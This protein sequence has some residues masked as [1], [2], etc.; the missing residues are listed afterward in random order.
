MAVKGEDLA[1]RVSAQVRY[2][3]GKAGFVV[4]EAKSQWSPVKRLVWL[5]FEIDQELS[6]VAVPDSK[7][8]STCDL[9][10]F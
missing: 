7:F 10:R 5:G 2:D 6:K 4:N 3:L 9:L 1:R 8:E